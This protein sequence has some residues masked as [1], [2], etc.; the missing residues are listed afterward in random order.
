MG[1][2]G[3]EAA[4]SGTR[5]PLTEL[6]RVTALRPLLPPPPFSS[7]RLFLSRSCN[8]PAAAL[9]LPSHL[10][11]PFCF[12]FL[13]VLRTR[14]PAPYFGVGD[15]GPR[16]SRDPHPSLHLSSPARGPGLLLGPGGPSHPGLRRCRRRRHHCLSPNGG[17]R[18][19]R[20]PVM[21]LPTVPGLLLPLVSPGTRAEWAGGGGGRRRGGEKRGG[22]RLAPV[23]HRPGPWPWASVAPLQTRP[24]VRVPHS[25][26]RP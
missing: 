3:P 9:S 23:G 11:A 12:N 20:W 14:A 17:V 24:E 22:R 16:L 5:A 7:P 8:T 25:G 1:G 18:G 2:W 6:Q 15:P 4:G 13:P 26:R 21:G 19:H 10:L